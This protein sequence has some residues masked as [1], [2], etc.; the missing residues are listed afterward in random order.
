MKNQKTK[1]KMKKNDSSCY[2][3]FCLLL[4]VISSLNLYSQD[5][6]FFKKFNNLTVD[7]SV[8]RTSMYQTDSDEISK[9]DVFIKINL[10]DKITNLYN[11]LNTKQILSAL[12]NENTDWAINLF[13]YSFY[14]KSATKFLVLKKREDWIKTS[15]NEDIEYW[16]KILKD[17][18]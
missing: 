1:N 9:P 11:E 3:Y 18:N 10:D 15:K 6:K 12:S 2:R 17:R 5:I 8:Y 14:G 7:Y 16:T 4:V 13:L